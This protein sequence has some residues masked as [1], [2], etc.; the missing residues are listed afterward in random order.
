VVTESQMRQALDVV[1]RDLA[2]TI[3]QALPVH[4]TEG[5]AASHAGTESVKSIANAKLLVTIPDAA[6]LLSI[7]KA[8]CYRLVSSGQI[9]SIKIGKLRR[10]PVSALQDFIALELDS[11]A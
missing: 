11:G 7:S 10:V 6:A 8:S 1:L 4:A 5:L 2:H 9:R 3:V